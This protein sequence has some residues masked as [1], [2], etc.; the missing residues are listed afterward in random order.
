MSKKSDDPNGEQL[1]TPVKYVIK[2]AEELARSTKQ[3]TV[4]SEHILLALV[5]NYPGPVERVITSLSA[6]EIEQRLQ[7]RLPSKEKVEQDTV[8]KRAL[9]LANQEGSEKVKLHHL[10]MAAAEYCDFAVAP[11]AEGRPSIPSK[12]TAAKPSKPTPTLDKFGRDLTHLAVEGK[13]HPIVGRDKQIDLV[14]D[15]LCRVFKRN[16]LLV[17]PAGVGKTAVVE[18]LALRIA[19]GNVTKALSGKRVIELNMG[20]LVAGTKY[21]GD[22]EERLMNVIKEASISDIILFIDEMHSVLGAGIAEGAPLDASTMLLPALQGGEISCIGATTDS[23]YHQHVEKDKALERRFQPIRIPELSPPATLAMLKELA[24]AKLEQPHDVH[25][26][27]EAFA[28]VVDLAG[29]YLRNRYF[30]DKAIDILDQA[31][32]RAVREERKQV[33][34]DDL[35][36][37]V[38]SLTG[39]PVGRLEDELRQRLEGLG[40]FLRGRILGQDDIIDPVVDIIWPKA[41][42][43]DLRPERPN[44]V[45][46]FVGPTG[47]GKTEFARALAEYL[48]GSRDKLIRIDMSEYAESYTASKLLGAPF[49]YI[50]FERGSPLLDAIAENP[51]SVLLLDEIEKAHPDIH[52]LFL[53]VFDSGVLTDSQGRHVY[54]SDVIIVMTGNIPIKKQQAIGFLG[55]DE[56]QDARNLLKDYFA[57]EFVN[58]IDLVGVFNSLP[59]KIVRQIVEERIVPPL[60]GKWQKKG[61]DLEVTPEAVTLL[62]GKGY[63]KQWGARHLERTVD[64]LLSSRLARFLPEAKDKGQITI[65]VDVRDDSLQCKLIGGK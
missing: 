65:R 25:I 6:H 34:V 44:A 53:Q 33:T 5:R 64:E 36:N 30:P 24:V 28:E 11:P 12:L 19:S 2:H 47:V 39:L 58:R 55:Q 7:G 22:F 18:G 60:E 1:S 51:F 41:L 48:F 40:A 23:A 56:V 35:R 4:T 8:L 38:S 15:T 16:P 63:S 57:P 54:F 50:G 27:E 59:I 13:L 42:G 43:V 61:I 14:A 32:G 9:S 26:E 29:R 45:L 46:L 17:G 20:T 62:V 10:V 31:V 3:A 49:G 21:R 52:K 37:V